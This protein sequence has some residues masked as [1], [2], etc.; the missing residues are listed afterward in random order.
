M[1][2][3]KNYQVGNLLTT[4]LPHPDRVEQVNRSHFVAQQ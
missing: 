3:K 4:H 2:T 1:R